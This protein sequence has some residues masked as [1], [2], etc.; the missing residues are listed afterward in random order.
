MAT[1]KATLSVLSTFADLLE[2]DSDT[3]NPA[4]LAFFPTVVEVCRVASSA[5]SADIVEVLETMVSIPS[6]RPIMISQGAADLLTCL[7]ERSD[8][9]RALSLRI[10]AVIAKMNA[11]SDETPQN[12][13]SAASSS[14]SVGAKKG[15]AAATTL[16]TSRASG[17]RELQ[18]IQLNMDNLL[19]QRDQEDQYIRALLMMDGVT[20]VTLDRKREVALVFA[21]DAGMKQ[22]MYETVQA[23]CDSIQDA[24]G[25]PRFVVR[26][27][28]AAYLE[29][30]EGEE[31]FFG[32]GAALARP[33]LGGGGKL[34]TL[35][36]IE[37][38]R[39][40]RRDAAAAQSGGWLSWLKW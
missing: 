28:H 24:A 30:D 14:T 9:T 23:T 29:D 12:V 16:G 1:D 8:T 35:A 32:A 11:R 27:E 10:S 33:G 37:A 26:G 22:A 17:R 21:Y 18:T 5:I 39:Q 15:A 4:V 40:R 3:V 20:S 34:G 2:G 6:C 31:D 38:D 7:A 25:K 36:D 19:G 13:V